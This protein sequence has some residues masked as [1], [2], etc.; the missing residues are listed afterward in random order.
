MSYFGVVAEEYAKTGL[1]FQPMRNSHPRTRRDVLLG[2]LIEAAFEMIRALP[3]EMVKVRLLPVGQE[4]PLAGAP[5]PRG[6]FTRW[7]HRGGTVR[8]ALIFFLLGA[9]LAVLAGL[10][11]G[12]CWLLLWPALNG[13]LLSAGYLGLGPRICGKRAD[14]RLAWWAV[15]LLLP[16]LTATWVLWHLGRRLSREPPCH[17]VAPALWVGRRPF[18]HELPDG[19][20]LVVDLT[21]EFIAHRKVVQGRTY[22]CLPTL[23]TAAPEEKAFQHVVGRIVGW[24][25]AV[26]V[27][28]AAGHGRS[29]A[30]AAAV[31]MARGLAGSVQEAEDLLRQARPGIRFTPAQRALLLRFTSQPV[32]T[33]RVDPRL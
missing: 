18:V 11:G 30:V 9:Y 32:Q 14:G 24:Q 31:V 16:Y 28:C 10:F 25:G 27:H 6:V 22:L 12:L 7:R 19:V 23:D 26:Y 3:Q 5:T 29:A 13:F 17:E 2:L 20:T 4:D 33:N 15:V 21:A 8:Y 1:F